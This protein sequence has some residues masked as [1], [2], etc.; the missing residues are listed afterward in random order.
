LRHNWD[1]NK[2]ARKLIEDEM[3]TKECGLMA[4]INENELFSDDIF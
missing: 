1:E 4:Q 2:R 3:K